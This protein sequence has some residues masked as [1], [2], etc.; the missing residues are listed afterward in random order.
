MTPSLAKPATRFLDFVFEPVDP[1]RLDML[2]WGLAFSYLLYLCL[3]PE[4]YRE[5]LSV[6]G[7]HYTRDVA[8]AG[9][10]F[11]FSPLPVAAVPWFLT[12]FMGSLFSIIC[13]WQTRLMTWICFACTFYLYEMEPVTMFTL[14]KLYLVAFAIFCLVPGTQRVMTAGGVMAWRQSAWPLRILQTTF[15]IHYFC[16]G[17]CKVWPGDWLTNPDVLWSQSQGLYATDA[18]AFMLRHL[19]RW[20]W[21][22]LQ[23]FALVFELA[24]PFLFLWRRLVP[25]GIVLNLLLQLGIALMMYKLIYFGMQ[26]VF[27]SLAFVDASTLR[28]ITGWL[29]RTVPG[30][31][32]WTL[33]TS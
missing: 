27:F 12:V 29:R 18:A 23:Y 11:Y 1:I 32:S 21:T 16:A 6:E 15:I 17:V 26:I 3:W 30:V 25:L 7:F 31:R 20:A 8:V 24:V 28:H 9:H 22:V 33:R 2:R 19:P 14:N 10:S 13:G 4:S 5:W